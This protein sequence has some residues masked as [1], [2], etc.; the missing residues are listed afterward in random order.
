[1]NL[2]LERL[3]YEI[4]GV[5]IDPSYRVMVKFEV[6]LADPNKSNI[7]KVLPTLESFYRQPVADL[8]KAWDGLLWFYLGGAD[9]TEA[10]TGGVA[11]RIYD[12][13]QDSPHI[14]T[15]FL[16][17][18]GIDLQ[19]TDLHWWAFRQ[20]FFDLPDTCLMGKIMG[21]R[22]ADTSRMKGAEK[23][24]YQSMQK[25]FTLKTKGPAEHLSAANKEAAYIYKVR[26]RYEEAQKWAQK[27]R[28]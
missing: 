3:P 1:M 15:A 7:E 27:E 17:V 8:Q 23:K 16:Q 2:L 13:E 14:Y 12:F 4:N 6:A 5:P 21:F 19:M 22:G 25:L 26:K 20:L 10:G 9:A 24:Y 28:K 11:K 18:Y